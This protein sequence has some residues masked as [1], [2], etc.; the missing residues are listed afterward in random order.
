VAVLLMLAVAEAVLV[1]IAPL[2][3]SEYHFQ[4]ITD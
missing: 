3:L 4:L 1:A 2:H